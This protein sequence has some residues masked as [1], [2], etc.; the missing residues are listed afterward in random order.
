MMKLICPSSAI[1]RLHS[2]QMQ[3]D[4][5]QLLESFLLRLVC[6]APSSCDGD[7]VLQALLEPGRP[8]WR[9]CFVLGVVLGV[10]IVLCFCVVLFFCL[11]GTLYFFFAP[12]NC[13]FN[14]STKC[15]TN[16]GL[17]GGRSICVPPPDPSVGPWRSSWTFL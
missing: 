8:S 6:N 9:W 3:S 7:G 11:R 10:G 17:P 1:V 16:E 4:V 14:S 12:I 13:S 15:F 2:S 5:L